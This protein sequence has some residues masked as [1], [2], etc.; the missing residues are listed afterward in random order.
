W[1]GSCPRRPTHRGDRSC[2]RVDAADGLPIAGKRDGKCEGQSKEGRQIMSARTR[3][4]PQTSGYPSSLLLLSMIARQSPNTT[5]RYPRSEGSRLT[6][7]NPSEHSTVASGKPR[8]KRD[9]P[10]WVIL[11]PGTPK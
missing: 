11:V 1:C 5:F 4:G 8:F 6:H 9:A 2:G 3:A 7:K 10:P